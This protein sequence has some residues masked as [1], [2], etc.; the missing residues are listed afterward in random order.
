M[1]VVRSG[2]SYVVQLLVAALMVGSFYVC[3]L[4]SSPSDLLVMM[5]GTA[6]FIATALLPLRL[7][8]VSTA[9]GEPLAVLFA[10][11]AVPISASLS[12]PIRDLQWAALLL[13]PLAMQTLWALHRYPPLVERD[14]RLLFS[15]ISATVGIGLLIAL[16]L[17]LVVL[18]IFLISLA[19]DDEMRRLGPSAFVRIAAGYF[20]G[21]LL[22]GTLV[23]VLRPLTRWPTGTIALGVLGGAI[24][25]G[26]VG[27]AVQFIE[28][29]EGKPLMSFAEQIAIAL[30]CGVMVGPPVAIGWRYG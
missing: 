19:A 29:S 15:R 9:G 17:T 8:R 20:A 5:T 26:A 7:G 10:G 30:A 3:M 2:R 22:A 27:P 23:G 6:G 14:N 24:V 11:C 13:A 21:A 28:L 25:Y 12:P 18:A 4:L 16:V 1:P